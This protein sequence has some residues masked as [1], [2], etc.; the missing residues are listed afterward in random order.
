MYALRL[1]C[2]LSRHLEEIR[3]IVSKSKPNLPEPIPEFQVVHPK[4]GTFTTV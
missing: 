4:K 2:H 3:G 1:V